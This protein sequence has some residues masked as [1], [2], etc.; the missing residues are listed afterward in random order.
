MIRVVVVDDSA[1]VRNTLTAILERDHDIEVV[2][3]ARD[4]QEALESIRTHDPD[5]VT[6]D[7]E[8]PKMD[9]LT[10]LRHIMTEMPRPVLMISSLTSDGAEAT[11][12]ALDL[13]AADFI[14]KQ[15]MPDAE[16]EKLVRKKVHAVAG[17]ILDR[18]KRHV[19]H[20]RPAVTPTPPAAHG[21][22]GFARAAGATAR[23]SQGSAFSH[24]AAAPQRPSFLSAHHPP[25]T[26]VSSLSSSQNTAPAKIVSLPPGRPVRDIIVIGVSTGGPP[27]VQKILSQLPA[28]LPAC[29]LI[30]QHMP[31][32]FT[33]PFARRLD[34]TS[35]LTVSESQE[36]E[37]LRSGH[38]YVCPGGKH[39]RV[40]TMTEAA[41]TAEPVEALYKPSANVLMETAGRLLGRKTL[42]VMLTG[43]GNDGLEG[44]RILKKEGGRLLAQSE[45]SC[46]VYGMPKAV[47]DEG[48]ADE[49][50][51]ADNM[52]QAIVDNLYK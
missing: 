26:H 52:A 2:G 27:V 41:V 6:L 33:G 4:G 17:S 31:A 15:R 10:A 20:A 32:T 5:V 25:A 8:M 45:A 50:V 9:G 35:Q 24:P 49:I 37:K 36:V 3:T 46:V 48:L 21:T 30:A 29:I 22:A 39:L 28:N 11:L 16:Y 23:G 40:K 42:G 12:K 34:S 43:M 1:F 14:E 47:V 18:I 38:V 7:I 19:R 13:G 51:D 44:A